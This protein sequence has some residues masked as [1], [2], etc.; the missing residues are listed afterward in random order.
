MTESFTFMYQIFLGNLLKLR[1]SSTVYCK[2]YCDI[3]V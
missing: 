3:T 1:D 2:D